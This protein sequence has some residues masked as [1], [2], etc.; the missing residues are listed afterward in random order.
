MHGDR[1]SGAGGR[2][3]SPP[4]DGVEG[5]LRSASELEKA[6]MLTGPQRDALKTL[7][8][9]GDAATRNALTAFQQGDSTE[10]EGMIQQGRLD[11]SSSHVVAFADD[12]EDDDQEASGSTRLAQVIVETSPNSTTNAADETGSQRPRNSL[13]EVTRGRHRAASIDLLAELDLDGVLADWGNP[14][15]PPP[16]HEV[17]SAHDDQLM[18]FDMEMPFFSFQGGGSANDSFRYDTQLSASP[19]TGGSLSS[20]IPRPGGRR[21][22]NGGGKQQAF[23]AGGSSRGGRCNS[24]GSY[25]S[26]GGS[27]MVGRN[28]SHQHEDVEIDDHRHMGGLSPPSSLTSETTGINARR[29]NH[30]QGREPY[31][32]KVVPPGGRC[33]PGSSRTNGEASGMGSTERRLHQQQQQQQ[34]GGGLWSNEAWGAGETT[35]DY[36]LFGSDRAETNTP[37]KLVAGGKQAPGPSAGPSVHHSNSTLESISGV[38]YDGKVSSTISVAPSASELVGGPA[39][40]YETLINF[41]RAKSRAQIHCVMCGRHPKPED[42]D[43]ASAG[44]GGGGGEDGGDAQTSGGT[45]S[46]SADD[47]STQRSRVVVIPRQNKDVC[48]ECDKALWRHLETDTHFKWCKGCK[49]FRNLTAFQEKICASKCDRCR[50][51][52]RQGYMRRKGG[53]GSPPSTPLNDEEP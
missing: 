16:S 15:K 37:P 20:S 1:P 2:S 28:Q 49:R 7:V 11:E 52:G 39:P 5:S 13:L 19:A 24:I 6:G 43:A 30:H 3:P 33:P 17:I 27:L 32:G 48:R 47:S 29:F 26:M 18:G 45:A 22:P 42:G 38:S 10:L 41:P 21:T 9:N 4:V 34:R 50:E 12:E 23:G 51:R 14:R 31:G 35:N 44:G 53:T 36:S 25:D 40:P 8:V 46:V